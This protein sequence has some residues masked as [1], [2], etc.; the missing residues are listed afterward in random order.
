M[1]EMKLDRMLDG[2][3]RGEWVPAILLLGSDVYLRDL[4]RRKIVEAYVPEN[5]RDW[6]V[7]RISAR[8]GWDEVIARAQTP[9]MLSK[10]QVV[11]VDD[12]ASVEKLGEKAREQIME[13]LHQYFESPARFTVLLLE[14]TTLDGRQKF[15]KLLHEKAVVV[16]LTI[17]KESAASLAAQM[18]REFA[19]EMDQ[20]AA[21]LLADIVNLEPARMHIEIEKL[22]TYV[23][24]RGKI[25]SR[26]VETLVVAARRNTVWQFTEMLANGERGAALQFLNN[27]LR[28]GDEPLAIIGA[29][30]WMYRKLIEAR[31]LPP[32]LNG[33]QAAR[34]LGMNPQAAESAIRQARRVS[35]GE[36]LAGLRALA[37]TDSELKA[38]NPNP[39]AAMEFLVARLTLS[40]GASA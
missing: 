13:A 32:R 4:C 2:I 18:A 36:L 12:V 14:A 40:A 3:A 33:F 38:A 17:G 20:D 26:D 27:L 25:T 19:A 1:A 8:E 34:E 15:S 30:A 6:A 10:L 28:E 9:P 22:A 29:L 11:L 16:E 37:E 31:D 23:G 35:K 5:A 21:M 39:N 24:A 7:K